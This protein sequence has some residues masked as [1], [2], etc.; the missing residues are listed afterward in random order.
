MNYGGKDHYKQV[1]PINLQNVEGLY[2]RHPT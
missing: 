2:L 1:E